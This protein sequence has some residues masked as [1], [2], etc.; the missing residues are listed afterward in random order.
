[1]NKFDIF[2]PNDYKEKYP[3]YKQQHKYKYQLR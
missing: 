1:M 3:E 2:Y